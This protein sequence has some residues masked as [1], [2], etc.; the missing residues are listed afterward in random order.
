MLLIRKAEKLERFY[1]F[2]LPPVSVFF[3]LLGLQLTIPTALS[4]QI[5]SIDLP[6]NWHEQAEIWLDSLIGI[7]NS[8]L[9]SGP[10]HVVEFVGV[11]SHPFFISKKWKE[12]TVTID[13]YIYHYPKL[14]YDIHQDLLLIQ[15][16]N[17]SGLPVSLVV[18]EQQ[19]DAFS[20]QKYPFK[21]LKPQGPESPL[22]SGYYQVLYA[23]TYLNLYAKR[24]KTEYLKDFRKEFEPDHQLFGSKNDQV[25][26]QIKS[27]KDIMKQFPE[28]TD[29]I[30]RYIKNNRL[31][32]K[33]NRESEIV[34]LIQ[35]CEQFAPAS[36]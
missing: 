26:F 16:Y 15:F 19:V 23:G 13:N 3:L 5:P 29:E 33:T 10:Q 24:A 9:F 12:G 22:K 28:H 1:F 7:E 8:P 11:I 30:A 2:Y 4:G 21:H 31:R 17:Q 27:E 34:Q 25:F 36:P 14:L 6:N 35:F 20:I 18:Q 32:I